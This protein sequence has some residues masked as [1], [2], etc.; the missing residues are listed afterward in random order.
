MNPKTVYQEQSNFVNINDMSHEDS[1]YIMG[2]YG[3]PYLD[4]S[5]SGALEK[6]S[7]TELSVID[8]LAS[9]HMISSL[10]DNSP[11]YTKHT[12]HNYHMRNNVNITHVPSV[13][14]ITTNLTLLE[15]NLSSEQLP[16][17]LNDD[18]NCEIDNSVCDIL[19]NIVNPL[20][21]MVNN[22][23]AL[24]SSSSSEELGHTNSSRTGVLGTNTL[25]LTSSS[26]FEGF[27]K[28]DLE[29]PSIRHTTQH[30]AICINIDDTDH[31]S[32]TG[33]N[34]TLPTSEM[35]ININDTDQCHTSV[36]GINS[37]LPAVEISINIDDTDQGHID[38]PGINSMLSSQLNITACV[39]G[40]M[41]DIQN[42]E[43]VD[44][45][46]YASSSSYD[47]DGFTKEDLRPTPKRVDSDSDI[48][49]SPASS[50]PSDQSESEHDDGAYENYSSDD[51]ILYQVSCSPDKKPTKKCHTSTPIPLVE[52]LWRTEAL[53][54]KYSVPLN[55]LNKCEIYD[56]SHPPPNWDNI[57]PY[58]GLEDC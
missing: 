15:C 43:S 58:S 21:E 40:I 41:D 27:T 28:E 45:D 20:E 44:T 48:Y 11:N 31:T 2:E 51:T 37:T 29:T 25:C 33:I 55:K 8:T 3:D 36:T 32:M 34:N 13:T 22:P 24:S 54:R 14:P 50:D 7:V 1:G 17:N 46:L 9:L 47:F 16:Q 23:P 56:L 30:S 42:D 49:S 19:L 39:S 10:Y 52:N 6:L 57:D 4:A 12:D 26:E 5:L 18:K 53:N 38:V 35:G